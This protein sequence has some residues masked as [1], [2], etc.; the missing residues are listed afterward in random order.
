MATFFRAVISRE[1][2]ES[3][4]RLLN[5]APKTFDE[6]E[7]KSRQDAAHIESSGNSI[8]YFDI[9]PDEFAADCRAT[10]A[11]TN[12]QSLNSFTFKTG[13]RKKK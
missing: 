13:T 7:H 12:L 5:D 6:W 3:F 8:V 9:D 1:N 4:R 10:G 11:P 2:Y